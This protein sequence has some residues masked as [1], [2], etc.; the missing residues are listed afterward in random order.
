[1]S[2]PMGRYGQRPALPLHL[3]DASE[4]HCSLIVETY[5]RESH[6]IVLKQ[7]ALK[8]ARAYFLAG[9]CY[10]VFDAHERLNVLYYHSN[11]VR[12]QKETLNA[13]ELHINGPARS[14]RQLVR[15]RFSREDEEHCPREQL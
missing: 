11:F 14:R 3:L 1:M 13:K 7:P 10:E 4:K 12:R 2:D 8:P 5:S 6:S 9:A 15:L